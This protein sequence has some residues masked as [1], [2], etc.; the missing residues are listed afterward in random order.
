M[1]LIIGKQPKYPWL[2]ILRR[3]WKL[4]EDAATWEKRWFWEK[5]IKNFSFLSWKIIAALKWSIDFRMCLLTL[6]SASS[7]GILWEIHIFLF[8]IFGSFSWNL[9]V[10][11]AL[12][13]LSFT[14]VLPK[15]HFSSVFSEVTQPLVNQSALAFQF[16]TETRGTR[17]LSTWKIIFLRC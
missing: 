7:M 4:R 16:H 5:E 1:T 6:M 15:P 14:L 10:L 8:H 17:S 12:I 11:L 9:K 2:S 3:A 13:L